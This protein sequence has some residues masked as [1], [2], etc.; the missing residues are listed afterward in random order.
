M[1]Q[2]LGPYLDQVD[3][4]SD[5]LFS[6]CSVVLFICCKNTENHWLPPTNFT[7]VSASLTDSSRIGISFFPET[8]GF[9]KE[10]S[11]APRGKGKDEKSYTFG[12]N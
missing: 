5:V 2:M 12:P 6:H 7:D 4:R 3:R 11:T 8:N 10:L 9:F 1:E